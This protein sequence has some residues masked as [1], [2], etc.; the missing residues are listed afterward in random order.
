M[1]PE[2]TET[3]EPT[4]TATDETGTD[5][6]S[7][8]RDRFTTN[9]RQVLGALGAGALAATAGCTALT[10]ESDDEEATTDPNFGYS[11]TS[12]DQVPESLSPDHTVSLHVDEE[13]FIMENGRPTGAEFGIF[14][15]EEAGLHVEP[16]AIV[17]FDLESPDHTIT[18]L[19]PG[20]GRQQRVPDGVPWFSSPILPKD[21]F[22]LYTF[23]EPGV[24]DLVCS[25]HELLGMGTRI[26][27]G[28]KTEPVVRSQGRPPEVLSAAL[29][30][31]G[32]PGEDGQPDL[33]VDPL[34]PQ[35][36]VDRGSVHTHDLQIDLGV[37]IPRPTHPDNI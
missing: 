37:S 24:Y 33:G 31:T 8:V 21:G 15:F 32:M 34:A 20:F 35:N 3:S 7:P 29:L 23:E 28:D 5:S 13:K 16:G 14:H 6:D 9:R 2:S 11:G 19:H 25:P 26:V 36:I 30:G 1:T 12:D 18:S 17:K 27:V 22:W 10:S 4:S